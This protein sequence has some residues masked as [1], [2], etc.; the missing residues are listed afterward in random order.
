MEV[1]NDCRDLGAHF[2]ATGKM[3]VG[4]TCTQRMRQAAR[5]AERLEK[6][7]AP[8]EKKANIIRSKNDIRLKRHF[9]LE[10]DTDCRMGS[11]VE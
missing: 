5:S 1:I 3:K 9:Q 4:T 6:H 2:N 7:R 10:G 8:Y 11:G